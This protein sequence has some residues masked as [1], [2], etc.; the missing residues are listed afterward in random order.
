MRIIVA[1]E[2]SGRTREALRKAGHDAWSCDLKPAE[3]GS[4]FHLQGDMFDTLKKQSP[5]RAIIAHPD[6]TY[7]CSSGLH[8]NTRGK[9][10]SDGRPRAAHTEDAI[11]FVRRILSLPIEFKAIENPIGCLSSR[12]RKPDQI[13]QPWQFGDDA[14]KA[15]CLWV[16]GLP[17]LRPTRMI[18][19]YRGREETLGQSDRQRPEPAW[20]ICRARGGT[21][22]H[23]SGHRGRLR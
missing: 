3:D 13:I 1:C 15:T 23:I 11:R 19:P 22:T 17:L 20:S 7:L 8:W 21:V 18:P 5:F 16:E 9:I 4:P 6:C 12:I 10:E 2:C 14:S